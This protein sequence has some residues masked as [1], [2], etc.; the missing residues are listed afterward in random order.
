MRLFR[1]SLDPC[2]ADDGVSNTVLHC[3]PPA[4]CF[5]DITGKVYGCPI[6]KLLGGKVRDKV[7]CYNGNFR[8]ANSYF[9]REDRS[10]EGY[11]DHMRAM[12]DAAPRF[13]C[14]RSIVSVC[15]RQ[16]C[17]LSCSARCRCCRLYIVPCRATRPRAAV[18]FACVLARVLLHQHPCA[19]CAR[20]CCDHATT[21][22][23]PGL[24]LLPISLL[25]PDLISS[26]QA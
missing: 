22:K 7:R 19:C 21:G 11:A 13:R 12:L 26:A 5:F 14:S 23:K 15:C 6:Y 20:M 10:P 2:S 8:P 25:H 16:L 24:L 18:C 1:C 3:R 17:P 4:G 9:D